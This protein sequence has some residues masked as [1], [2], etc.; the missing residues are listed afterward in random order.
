MTEKRKINKDDIQKILIVKLSSIGDVVHSLP[1]LKAL[2]DTFPKAYI[3]W[4]V[5]EK[6]K[7]VVIGNPYLDEVIIFEKERWKKELFKTKSAR[8]SV[9]EIVVF[10]RQLREKKFDIALDLQG[11]LR[12]GLI[13]YFSGAK[14]RVGYKDSREVSHLF[15]NIKVPRNKE[16]VHA[17]DSYLQ[18]ARYLGAESTSVSFP[19][20]VSPEDRL[21]A[22]DF[23]KRHGWT[24][25]DMLVGINPGASIPHKRWD[26]DNFAR[27]GGHLAKTLDVKVI[28]FGAPSDAPLVQEIA[29]KMSAVHP[30]DASGKTTIKQLAALIEKCALFIGNDTGPMHIAVAM[31]TPVIALFGPDNPHRTGPYGMKNK[32]LYHELSCS[33]C[34]RNPTCGGEY[35]CL[36]LITVQDVMQTAESMLKSFQHV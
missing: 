19:L 18:L 28:L 9:D 21:F 25:K 36:K 12:S 2:R 7:D 11:L 32:I 15:Y 35:T 8:E 24:E 27:L 1:T 4:V 10:A 29:S 33:P 34:I 26:K 16:I 5:E 31:G 17:V 3:A 23:I 30:L 14:W 6:S 13:A 20:W 22:D